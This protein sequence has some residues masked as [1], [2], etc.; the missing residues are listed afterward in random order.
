MIFVNS[1]HLHRNKYANI[2]SFY[3]AIGMTVKTHIPQTTRITSKV[4][5]FRPPGH[6]KASP[7][8]RDRQSRTS[9]VRLLPVILS[10]V[11]VVL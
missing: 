5:R 7:R 3:D 11:E 8:C 9:R 4:V 6:P 2:V 10:L 1:K